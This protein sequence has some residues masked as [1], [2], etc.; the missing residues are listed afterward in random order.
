[1]ADRRILAGEWDERR[2]ASV[3]KPAR[4][5]PPFPRYADRGRWRALPD[6]L[7][8][9]VTRNAQ[10]SL[11]KP[12]DSLPATLALDYQR[13]G[14]RSH[15]EAQSFGRRKR[16]RDLVLAECIEG[17]GRFLDEI[18]NGVWLISEE[19]WWG[20]PAYLNLQQAGPG[21]PDVEEPVVDLFAA[22]T[23]SLMAWTWW[24]LGEQLGQ[25]SPL[26]PRRMQVEIERRIL[27]PCRQ[28][29][30]FWWMGLDPRQSR[31]VNNWNPWINS[32]WLTCALL[33]EPEERRAGVVHKILRSLDRFLDGYHDDGGCDEGPGYWNRAGASLL[34][35]LE[36]LRAA[37]G[38]RID[39]YGNPLVKEIGRYIYRVHIAGAWYVN[40]CD[41][42]AKVSLA[43]AT[44]YVYGQRIGDPKLT[45]QGAFARALEDRSDVEESMGRDLRTLF[46][47][48]EM[49]RS[50]SRPPLVGEA[51]FDGIQV[52]AA[53]RQEGA[54]EGL[55]LAAAGGHNGKSHNHNDVGN[56]IVYA[57]GRPAIIDLGPETYSAKTFSPQRYEIWTMRSAYH[58]CPLIDGVE[59]APGRQYT[60]RDV[61]YRP[62]PAGPELRMDIAAAYPPQVGVRKWERRWQLDRASNTIMLE[63]QWVLSVAGRI[64]LILMT[65]AQPA[66]SSGGVSI[67]GRV[68]VAH[69]PAWQAVIEPI[70]VTDETLRGSWGNRVW[71]VHLTQAQAPER[72]RSVLTIS[73]IS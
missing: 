48:D 36:L 50:D 42:P 23:G 28:R 35:C 67:G 57:D 61:A 68:R 49:R 20:V 38:G 18:L 44:T 64:E 39:V 56:F 12:W 22:E 5:W 45:A 30:D 73:Q 53:R 65:A 32:N 62:T 60:A 14:N 54:L 47:A 69:D 17:Q 58:N 27:A 7:R 2:I 8:E 31:E 24:L 55:F 6:D 10:R 25:L 26:A 40:F 4:Q 46:V 34:D 9:T 19:T 3:L 72:G 15:Y 43:A 51:W 29:N 21:L 70:D 71:R 37:T 41:A 59:Q 1:M 13:T 52:L 11:G 16:L 33:L 63:D 66:A